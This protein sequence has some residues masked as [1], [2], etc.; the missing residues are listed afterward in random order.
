MKKM[1]EREGKGQ[2]LGEK[3]NYGQFRA[4]PKTTEHLWYFKVRMISYL[5]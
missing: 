4:K 2:S 1:R 5:T 3:G